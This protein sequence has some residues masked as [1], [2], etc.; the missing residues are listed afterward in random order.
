MRFVRCNHDG[1]VNQFFHLFTISFVIVVKYRVYLSDKNQGVD[2]SRKS[3]DIQEINE[4]IKK[5]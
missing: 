1:A 4:C 3:A 2:H 5:R